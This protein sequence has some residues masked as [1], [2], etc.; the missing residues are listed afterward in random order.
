MPIIQD[1]RQAVEPFPM[2]Q[3]KAQVDP[4]TECTERLGLPVLRCRCDGSVVSVAPA[5]L[6]LLGYSS[7]D[8]VR[9]AGRTAASFWQVP[10]TVS[11][12]LCAPPE[13]REDLHEFAV[14]GSDG[15]PRTLLFFRIDAPPTEGASGDVS[16]LVMDPGSILARQD[17]RA[18]MAR[19]ESIGASCGA[20]GHKL[21]NLLAGLIGYL[22]LLRRAVGGESQSVQRY[23]DYLD[24]TGG[25]IRDLTN[26]L[27]VIAQKNV[28]YAMQPVDSL[29][30]TKRAVERA[31]EARPGLRVVLDEPTELTS[32]EADRAA[33]EEAIAH[34]VRGVT[35]V[36]PATVAVSVSL[37][38]QEVDSDMAGLLGLPPG[39]YV[40]V[41]ISH[42]HG[43]VEAVVRERLFDP[44]FTHDGKGKGAELDL[45][46]AWGIV[47][48]HRGTISVRAVGLE[49]THVEVV[50][51]VMQGRAQ[52]AERPG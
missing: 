8:R 34:L 27:I 11:R 38:R 22:T 16:L 39:A 41:R 32:I 17:R 42:T 47:A 45:C 43:P 48:L 52:R 31:C 46:K 7:A 40:V 4:V 10:D 23:L 29:L 24:E 35:V 9:E 26:Q 25:S 28:S 49:A 13:R 2:D 1:R 37:A 3:S 21:N 19:L 44:Y 50:L 12:W 18:L 6:A 36:L 14:N 5:A 30:L 15:M 51:P 20:V 33:L